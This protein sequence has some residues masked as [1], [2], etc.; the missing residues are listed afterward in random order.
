VSLFSRLFGPQR[1]S[2][3]DRGMDAYNRGDY[4]VAIAE[5]EQVVLRSSEGSPAYVLSRFFV[6][7][8]RVHLGA[9]YHGSGRLDEA[10]A[11]LRKVLD[12]HPDF[13]DV[14][15]R[16][17]EI[18]RERGRMD[19]AQARFEDAL[20]RNPDY[21]VARISLALLLRERGR[22]EEAA[23]H[24]RGLPDLPVPR[25][26]RE[27]EP[28]PDDAAV[29]VRLRSSQGDPRE[30]VVLVKE[31]LRAYRLGDL[32]G[33]L[34]SL[35]RAVSLC[36][37]HAD[38][39][40]RRATVLAE[41]GRLPEAREELDT[42]LGMNPDYEEARLKRGVLR[43]QLGDARGAVDDLERTVS[44]GTSPELDLLLGEALLWAGRAVDAIEPLS[45]AAAV[46][47]ASA[48]AARLLARIHVVADRPHLALKALG[49]LDDPTSRL[50][51]SRLLLDLGRPAQAA[52]EADAAFAAE[53]WAEAALVAAE[54]HRR[55]GSPDLATARAMDAVDD[56]A[57][58]GPAAMVLARV[59]FDTGEDEAA[60]TWIRRLPLED[61]HAYPSRVL[62]GRILARLGRD[63][64][65]YAA[66][67]AGLAVYGT[68][69]EASRALGVLNARRGDAD[70]AT[71]LA[72]AAIDPFDPLWGTNAPGAG[73]H[74]R[75]VRAA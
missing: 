67:E 11:I 31:A 75:S 46:P 64:E 28:A 13:P 27:A 15:H 8:S 47:Q 2:S 60:L 62:E 73:W 21:T 48:P 33:A 45:R 51:R 4:E 26:W 34:V 68:G 72:G 30:G 35:D 54:A 50:F 3:Y 22:L 39:R 12:D 55:S 18:A 1:T 41:I 69:A 59:A 5:L 17:G 16:L 65:A 10:T 19:E 58:R 32:E 66:L 43:L 71:G 49:N 70:A 44:M 23:H 53:E 56:D 20:R 37:G 40:C 9:A 63:E 7:Q 36:P 38:I 61:R 25:S 29:L 74:L 14:H 6:T 42:A 24:L 52:T 57:L